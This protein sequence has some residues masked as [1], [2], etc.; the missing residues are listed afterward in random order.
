MSKF[1]EG[2]NPSQ[3]TA[4]EALTGPIQINAV[5]GSGKTRVLT[6][7]I[8][9][10]LENGIK[11][12]QILCTTFT[13]KAT[14]EMTKRLSGMINPLHLKML[15]LGTFHS[16]AHRILSKEYKESGHR[17]AE[18]LNPRNRD[19]L[20]VNY[21]LKKFAEQIKKNIMY[22]RTVEFTVKEALTQMPL[23]QLL[24][25]IGTSK[26]NYM[27][28][29]EF[30][31][32][33]SG[34]GAR[35]EAYVEFFMRYEQT[36]NQECKMDMDDLLFN[37]VKL[38]KDRPDVLA[39]YQ[40]YYKYL[41]VDEAQDNNRLQYML[42]RMIGAPE[43]NVFIVGDDDQS[44]YGF[45]GAKPE[46]FIHFT[47]NYRGAKQ[48]ALEDNYRSNPGILD[49][50]NKLIRNNTIRLDKS[51]RAHKK[52]NSDCVNYTSYAS[53]ESEAKGT[54]QEIK[55]LIE[56]EEYEPKK[57]AILYRTNAQSRALEDQ[58]IIAGLPYVIHGG[59]SFYERKEVKD[60]ISYLELAIN[61]NNDEA[62][63]RVVNVPSRYLGKAFMDK[64]ASG[65][66]SYFEN[67]MGAAQKEYEQRGI[68]DF[69]NNVVALEDMVSD[70]I[71]PVD[72]VD[73]ILSDSGIG[74]QKYFLDDLG[75]D[76]EEEAKMENIATLKYV[77]GRFESLTEFLEYIRMM[78]TTAKMDINGVQLMT[79]H[80]SKGLE[81]PVVF[82][83]GC[84]EGSLPHFKAV[85]AEREG[86]PLAIEEERRLMYVA[87]T[88]AESRC[89]ASSSLLF[90]GKLQPPS[91]FIGE[92]GLVAKPDKT[93]A[94][95]T[96]TKELQ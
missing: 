48:I 54:V 32:E 75:D 9:Y 73:Y 57:I 24:K 62:F 79:V 30:Q 40:K 65:K 36:K 44:M 41:L 59:I 10:M 84:N 11:A 88:R 56:K 2:L 22:D 18:A 70:G 28:W 90:N 39:K 61:R 16:I 63:K 92:M 93:E 5:A 27:T 95:A 71:P 34:K 80:K 42:I 6:H 87:A 35:S 49:V 37:L 66:G 53:E 33:N 1:L 15:T 12:N 26:N 52:D 81:F 31:A 91:R 55:V 4:V 38:F 69:V 77:L 78:T 64:V 96:S 72:V 25:A 8:G 21:G 13:K 86:R 67:C 68:R 45:R 29:Q 60:I 23:P 7:R 14:E 50:A 46:E 47:D 76:E 85:E 19:G 89:Y 58:L 74:Y 51:L 3:A 83:V 17:L 82:I 43:Y 94:A 20:L